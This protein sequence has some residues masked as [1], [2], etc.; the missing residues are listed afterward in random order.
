MENPVYM[1]T[2][3]KD[4]DEEFCYKHFNEAKKIQSSRDTILVE[5]LHSKNK[6]PY[7]PWPE[8]KFQQYKY[9]FEELSKQ[10][11]LVGFIFKRKTFCE[12]LHLGTYKQYNSLDEATKEFFHI[13]P[14]K[15]I[16]C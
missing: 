15:I 1:Y 3:Y 8:N 7:F 6:F 14:D 13:K 9:I 4:L 10:D 2:Y 11:N 16:R 12:L 5:Y